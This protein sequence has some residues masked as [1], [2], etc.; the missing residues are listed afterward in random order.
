MNKDARNEKLATRDKKSAPQNEKSL[1]RDEKSGLLN[2]KL[3]THD[4][5]SG[6]RDKKKGAP[7]LIAGTPD[8]IINRRF[9]TW[10]LLF[11]IRLRPRKFV[12]GFVGG[13]FRQIRD[14]HSDCH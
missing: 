6:A 14:F 4:E 7:F 9:S 3:A 1:L 12:A 2:Q 11:T 8:S 13:Q 5:K 10:G